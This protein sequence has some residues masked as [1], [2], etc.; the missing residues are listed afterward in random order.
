MATRIASYAVLVLLWL[1]FAFTASPAELGCALAAAALAGA[2]RIALRDRAEVPGCSP[3]RWIA[4]A[5]WAWPR[6]VLVD[7]ARVLAAVPRAG[8]RPELGH[9]LRAEL[10]GGAEHTKLAWSIVGTSISPNAYVVGWDDEARTVVLH[11]LVP[12]GKPAGELLWWPR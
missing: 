1:A 11:E 7:T 5:A 9:F 6:R 4:Q 8:S 10:P 2:C 12:T 3:L